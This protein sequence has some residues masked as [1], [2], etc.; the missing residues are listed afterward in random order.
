MLNY[1]VSQKGYH[2]T[3]DDNINNNCPIPVIFGTNSTEYAIERWFNI[4]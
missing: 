2:P 3:T 1:T 4:T